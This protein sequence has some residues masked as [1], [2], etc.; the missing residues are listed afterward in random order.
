MTLHELIAKLQEDYLKRELYALPLLIMDENGATSR[1]EHIGV[2][3][4]KVLIVPLKTKFQT[5]LMLDT[6]SATL[7][8]FVN[9]VTVGG[10]YDSAMDLPVYMGDPNNM[11]AVETIGLTGKGL[12]LMP[13]SDE[14]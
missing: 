9:H 5:K 11:V 14:D 8:E 3:A 12:V 13:A 6:F 4:T 1:I 2:S 7:E 10:E